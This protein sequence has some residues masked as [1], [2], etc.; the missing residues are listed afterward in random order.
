[1]TRIL[2]SGE[3][4]LG[5]SEFQ[6][7]F[8]SLTSNRISVIG[9]N[10]SGKTTLLRL[11]AGHERL[12][13]GTLE[14][15]SVIYDDSTF[16][17]FIP[18]HQRGLV[19]QHQ[20]GSIFPHL[21][22]EDNVAF[23]Y[24]ST[25][26]SKR[27]ARLLAQE[28][29][30]AFNLIGIRGKYPDSLSGGQV[31][32]TSLARSISSKP[33]LLMLDEPTSALDIESVNQVHP[34]L[35]NLD[36][37]IILVSHSPI[38][39]L[40]LSSFVIAVEDK[41]IVQYGKLETVASRPATPWLSKFF[42][43]NLI[44]GRATGFDFTTKTGAALQLAEPHSGEVEISFP[45]S[46]VSLHLNPPTGSPRNKWQVTVT[47]LTRVNNLVKVQLS[48]AF[49]CYATITVASFEELKIALGNELWASAKATEL[50]VLPKI[51]P[52]RT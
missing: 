27:K 11:L 37:T 40:K 1:M 14:I 36:T 31:A 8:E 46:A 35:Q 9:P 18:P 28:T 43:L 44:S 24:R 48:G 3:T 41:Q 15:D 34:L 13:S 47:G 49:N 23:P 16:I 12:Y 42:D 4:R 25:K 21:T 33:G 5:T 50:N 29:L 51:I 2:L 45:S 19:L 26:T 39:V 6:F 7:N 32:R 17:N 20:D 38:E 30:K 52:A 22:V 10:G